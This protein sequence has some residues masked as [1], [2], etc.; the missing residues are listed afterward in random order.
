MAVLPI[1]LSWEDLKDEIADLVQLGL[2]DFGR[3][4]PLALTGVLTAY[5][6]SCIALLALFGILRI[7]SRFL[8]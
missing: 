3:D 5:S 7:P 8:R 1:S 6:I 2:A 4:R